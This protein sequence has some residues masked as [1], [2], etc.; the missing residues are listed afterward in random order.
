MPL[1]LVTSAVGLPSQPSQ[2][3]STQH[4]YSHPLG[5]HNFPKFPTQQIKSIPRLTYKP[6]PAVDQPQRDA[7]QC[8]N[9]PI[10]LTRHGPTPSALLTVSGFDP[11][12]DVGWWWHRYSGGPTW[13]VHTLDTRS[14][15]PMDFRHVYVLMK[16]AGKDIDKY[17]RHYLVCLVKVTLVRTR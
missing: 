12:C 2:Q 15:P 17:L 9:H 8:S 7:S 5:T 4:R 14:I 11:V 6:S 16:K 13:N 3:E 1:I 10:L